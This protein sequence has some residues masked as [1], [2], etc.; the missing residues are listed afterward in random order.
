M[1]LDEGRRET[2]LTKLQRR[3]LEMREC[4]TT[5]PSLPAVPR[6]CHHRQVVPVDDGA[7][8]LSQPVVLYVTVTPVNTAL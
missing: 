8:L 3:A 7:P 2:R 5:E 1:E 6:H 4:E